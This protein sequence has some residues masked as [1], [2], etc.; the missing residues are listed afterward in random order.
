MAGLVK[1]LEGVETRLDALKVSYND[2]EVPERFK[3]IL[4]DLNQQDRVEFLI[5][6]ID[7]A[8]FFPLKGLFKLSARTYFKH[9]K[10]GSRLCE[11]LIFVPQTCLL[12]N[13]LLDLYTES[14]MNSFGL[15]NATHLS[16]LLQAHLSHDKITPFLS[17]RV[18]FC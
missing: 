5:A 11:Y 6:I 1:D 12:D 16:W 7:A 4:N 10:S 14:L 8:P 2:I 13:S 15:M 3:K 18:H 17:A 9:R